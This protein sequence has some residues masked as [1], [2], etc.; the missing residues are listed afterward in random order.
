[1]G[2]ETNQV[3]ELLNELQAR[4]GGLYLS[5]LHAS[6]YSAAVYAALGKM[7]LR[8]C[9]LPVLNKVLQYISL[10]DVSFEDMQSALDFIERKA[11]I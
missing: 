11:K 3:I 2:K 7:D 8:G 6:Q 10:S 9:P 1:M 4:T 5:D